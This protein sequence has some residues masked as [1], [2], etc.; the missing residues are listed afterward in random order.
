MD[1]K[2]IIIEVFDDPA[3]RRAKESIAKRCNYNKRPKLWIRRC[4]SASLNEL[5]CVVCLVIF[6]SGRK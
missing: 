2:N 5:V 6:A 1:I 3:I 4:T